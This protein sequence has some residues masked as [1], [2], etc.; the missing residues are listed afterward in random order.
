MN[1]KIT[2]LII[3]GAL[4]AAGT[5][6]Y[7]AVGPFQP[8]PSILAQ[9]PTLHGFTVSTP[10]LAGGPSA[11]DYYAYYDGDGPNL[12]GLINSY[13]DYSRY[14]DPRG[15]AVASVLDSSVV[16]NRDDPLLTS[17]YGE[18]DYLFS[19]DAGAPA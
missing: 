5:A 18:F 11:T 6:A 2:A 4:L 3:A 13:D 7:A 8:T 1:T 14:S 17:L 10:A 12:P 16:I 19:T 15:V 9:S